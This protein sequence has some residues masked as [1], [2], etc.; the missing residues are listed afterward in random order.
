MVKSVYLLGQLLL[1]NLHFDN[2]GLNK[3]DVEQ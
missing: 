1:Q 2:I 3:A